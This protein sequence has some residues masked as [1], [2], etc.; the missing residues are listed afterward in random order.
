MLFP[1]GVKLPAP[2]LSGRAPLGRGEEV[3]ERN[4]EEG[5]AGLGQHVRTLAQLGIHMEATAAAVH[6]PGGNGEPAVD[7]NGRPVADEHPD[8]DAWEPVPC[9]E[10]SARL[11]QGGADEPS[12][13][14][15]RPGLVP[16]AERELRLVALDALFG[17]EGEMDAVRVVSAP[18]AGWV[19]MRRYAVFYR[20]PPRS[21]WAL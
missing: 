6:H 7:Q 16:F 20:S 19:V 5:A 18:P 12:V 3:L 1:V 8:G 9:G 17:W 14:D 2:G 13:D 11:V 21:K 4:V 10:Q 15:P